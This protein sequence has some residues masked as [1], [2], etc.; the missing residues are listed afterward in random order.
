MASLW[1]L[2]RNEDKFLPSQPQPPGTEGG[3]CPLLT[4][5][6]YRLQQQRG[7]E[8]PLGS[9]RPFLC[10]GSS[11]QPSKWLMPGQ[12]QSPPM[13]WGEGGEA[14]CPGCVPLESPSRHLR[15][16][17]VRCKVLWCYPICSLCCWGK[18][19]PQREKGT[20]SNLHSQMGNGR[21][22]ST[23][24]CPQNGFQSHYCVSG[25][26]GRGCKTAQWPVPPNTTP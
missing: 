19:A 12:K 4:A 1:L 5:A 15:T 24:P 18:R 9:R 3:M 11:M 20:C 21:G 8:V 23:M 25:R 22:L 2:T 26:Q 13:G 16:L 14:Q 7:A 10:R 6:K 17:G